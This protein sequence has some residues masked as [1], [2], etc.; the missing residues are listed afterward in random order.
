MFLSIL[1]IVIDVILIVLFFSTRSAILTL[2][3]KL[4]VLGVRV[5]KIDKYKKGE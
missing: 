3:G 1:G 5:A 4:D 2:K